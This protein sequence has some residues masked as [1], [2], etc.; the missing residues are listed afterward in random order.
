MK[1]S[2][3]SKEQYRLIKQLYG[4]P[5]SLCIAERNMC[6]VV[7]RVFCRG[8][9]QSRDEKVI[10]ILYQQA[11]ILAPLRH[12]NIATCYGVKKSARKNSSWCRNTMQTHSFDDTFFLFVSEYVSGIDLNILLQLHFKAGLL[13]PLPV[14]V[15]IVKQ[16][17]TA[18]AYAHKYTIHSDI[19][20]E[21]II[22]DKQGFCKVM[23]FGM[24]CMKATNPV[25]W[26]ETLMYMSPEQICNDPADERTDIFSLGLIAYQLLTGIPLLFAAPSLCIEDQAH[27]IYQQMK[28]IPA[29]HQVV[30]SIPEELSMMVKKMLGY[31]PE[32]R[33]QR[34]IKIVEQLEQKYPDL[35]IGAYSLA[36]YINCFPH[37]TKCNTQQKLALEFLDPHV[38]DLNIE[39]YT[40]LGKFFLRERKDSFLFTM[41][42]QKYN[43]R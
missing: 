12:D 1:L 5:G 24:A 10:D 28:N 31:T 22:I 30:R 23:E 32:Y 39:H 29:P 2:F 11:R 38:R 34:A 14:A 25:Y 42:R 27:K 36:T 18:L 43:I 33:Y 41:L 8:Y 17:A 21:N 15:C 37:F 19:S 3:T 4:Y 9:W 40:A 7:D 35:C 26:A 13:M 16:I 6:G 20:L